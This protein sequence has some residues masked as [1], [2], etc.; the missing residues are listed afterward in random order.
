MLETCALNSVN[1]LQFLLS[2]QIT[3]EGLIKMAGR[4]AK[5]SGGVRMDDESE[6]GCQSGCEPNPV[7]VST[8]T[9]LHGAV[10]RRDIGIV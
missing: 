4:R 10:E 2:K 9:L 6:R 7:V 8:K 3:L 1:A 5:T